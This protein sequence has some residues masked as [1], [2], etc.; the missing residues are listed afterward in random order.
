ME[1][2]RSRKDGGCGEERIEGDLRREKEQREERERG[3]KG[4]Q[5]D[6]EEGAGLRN[7]RAREKRKLGKEAGV[8]VVGEMRSP[9]G[10]GVAP[11][12]RG[13]VWWSQLGQPHRLKAPA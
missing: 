5:K 6:G 2:E 12:P 4:E 7:W 10:T 8:V 3:V 11:G 13:L 1:R 9:A